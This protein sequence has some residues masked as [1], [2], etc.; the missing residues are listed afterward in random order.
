MLG[1]YLLHELLELS[2]V[3]IDLLFKQAGTVLQVPSYV[4]HLLAPR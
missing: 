1:P 3:S 4:T 2:L